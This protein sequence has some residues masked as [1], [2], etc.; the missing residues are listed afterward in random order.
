MMNTETQKALLPEWLT[1][2][3]LVSAPVTIGE[4]THRAFL[5]HNQPLSEELIGAFILPYEPEGTYDEFTEYVPCFR[6]EHTGAHHVCVYWRASLMT[7]VY[8]LATFSPDGQ[9]I[10]RAMIAGTYMQDA[11]LAQR[12][13]FI[14]E[15]LRVISSEGRARPDTDSFDLVSSVQTIFSISDKGRVVYETPSD[16]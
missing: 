9:Q 6:L 3:P 13:A 2:I 7:Y 8:F 1:K 12:V 11:L 5:E 10:D 16:L 4:E 15:G 14:D